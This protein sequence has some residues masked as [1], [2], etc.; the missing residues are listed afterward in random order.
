MRWSTNKPKYENWESRVRTNFAWWPT[1]LRDGSLV[2]LEKYYV[3]VHFWRGAW[4]HDGPAHR[5]YF[6]D[7]AKD[8]QKEWVRY[9]PGNSYAKE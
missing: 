5:A 8:I 7:E 4:F 1:R 2:W 3:C 9:Y 6:L